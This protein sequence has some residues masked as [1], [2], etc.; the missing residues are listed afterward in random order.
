MKSDLF[1]TLDEVVNDLKDL[2]V[3]WA[4]VG[5]IAYQILVDARFTRD[6]DIA[7]AVSGDREAEKLIRDLRARG[8]QLHPQPQVEHLAAN[9]LATIRL[10][11]PGGHHGGVVV[12]LLFASSGIE[13]EIVGTAP[14]IEVLPGMRIPVIL[15]EHLLA[16]KILAGRPR[17]LEDA[18]ALLGTLGPLEIHRT[19]EALDLI[20][21]RSFARNKDLQRELDAL[22]A[23]QD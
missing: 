20:D 6:I 21:R 18:S 9:R 1:S 12:D 2:R 15:K 10:I 19:R 16:V 11:P 7:V 8:Y 17:D 3:A 23:A 22:I 4:L 14:E 13:P 5:G